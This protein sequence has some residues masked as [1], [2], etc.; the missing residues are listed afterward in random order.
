MQKEKKVQKEK[1]R[2]AAL[3]DSSED[4][5]DSGEHV[6]ADVGSDD[7]RDPQVNRMVTCK[8]RLQQSELAVVQHELTAAKLANALADVEQLKSEL[9][10]LKAAME[11]TVRLRRRGDCT[12]FQ[13]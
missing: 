4:S 12:P 3:L 10:K 9:A 1:K 7:D 13:V 5:E 6:G 8:E 2:K 11:A